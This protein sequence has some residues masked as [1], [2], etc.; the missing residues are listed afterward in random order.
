K[1][2]LLT[3]EYPEAAQ[4]FSYSLIEK[5]RLLAQINRILKAPADVQLAHF[6]LTILKKKNSLE[7]ALTQASLSKYIGKS[8]VTIWKVLK[9][10]EAKGLIQLED[11]KISLINKKKLGELVSFI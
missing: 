6:I 2:E 7:I 10:W 1:F 11:Q 4:Q 5:V 8:R 9:E 3:K